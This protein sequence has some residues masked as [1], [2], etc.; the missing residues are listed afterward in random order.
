VEL[1]TKISFSFTLCS[2]MFQGGMKA[3]VWT[4]TLQT[5][6]M[7]AGVLSACIKATVEVG[8]VKNVI[9]ALQRGQRNTL[10]K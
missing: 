9:E 2:I 1:F 7:F 6:V 8:G 3:V 5:F 10:W 4:D